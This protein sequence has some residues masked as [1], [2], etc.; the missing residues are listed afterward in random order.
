ME[1]NAEYA[2]KNTLV[3]NACSKAGIPGTSRQAGKFRRGLG[4]AYKVSMKLVDIEKDI[5]GNFV[6]IINQ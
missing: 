4:L 5:A 2:N 1:T 3:I 6:R